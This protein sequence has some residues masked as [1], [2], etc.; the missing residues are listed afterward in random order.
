VVQQIIRKNKLSHSRK[1]NP[2]VCDSC[3]LAKIHQFPYPVSTS[4]STI[5]FEQVF[6][7]VRG[8]A[9][10]SV[11]KHA[12]YVSFIDDYSKLIWIYLLKKRSEVY[13][14]FLNFQQLVER[15]FGRKIITM[16]T[17]WGGEYEK[18]HCFFQ[19][20]GITH[21]VSYPH[22]HQQ[23]SSAERKHRHIVEV[24]LALLA[25]ASM[26][27]KFWDEAS[28][29]ATFLVNF[30]PSKVI[31]FDTPTER[32]LSTNQNYDALC[33]F[34][35]A[36]WP[37]LRPYNKRK[38]AFRSTRYVLLGYSS[39]H[40]GVK[41]LDPSTGCVY[42]ST[43]VVFDESVFP[44]ANLNPNAGKRLQKDILLF[45][46]HTSSTSGDAHI[47]DYMLLPVVPNVTNVNASNISHTAIQVDAHHNAEHDDTEPSSGSETY[48]SSATY[49]KDPADAESTPESVGADL[50]VDP[51]GSTTPPPPAMSPEPTSP[52]R[53]PTPS[54]AMSPSPMTPSMSSDTENVVHTPSPPPSPPPAPPPVVPRTQLQHGIKNQKHIPMK[55]F[56]M[57]CLL[58]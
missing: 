21:H 10:A 44:F 58:Q 28:L 35:C 1:I 7:D 11:G 54:S 14:I 42:I 37:N 53:S 8:P 22:A 20:V 52:A 26:P 51:A 43:N 24:G 18:L 41:C 9:P 25:H 48:A 57:A 39:H 2:Y 38:L 49:E 4:V 31:C 29:T 36:C 32:L 34:G 47:D 27:L 23:N 45:P 12:Y 15:K 16:Q 30:L 55:L 19:K 46:T 56:D 50:E 17:D 40:K 3:Q 6:S 33:I 5:P 13:Q